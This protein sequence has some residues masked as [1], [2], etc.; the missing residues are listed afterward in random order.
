ML[1]ISWPSL[2]S[3][4]IFS[5]S[6]RQAIK[7]AP[8]KVHETETAHEKPARALKHLLKLNHVE[9]GLFDRRKFPSQISHVSVIV[10]HSTGA[11]YVYGVLIRLILTYL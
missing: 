6:P 8:V 5:S 11:I 7:L 10:Y 2:P 4:N 3:F 9:N 1:T